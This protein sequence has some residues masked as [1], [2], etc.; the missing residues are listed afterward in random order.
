MVVYKKNL[1]S[2]YTFKAIQFWEKTASLILSREN[3][4]YELEEFEKGASDPN[5][6]FLKSNAF[7]SYFLRLSIK[8]KN[9]KDT[10][11]RLQEAKFRDSSYEV[12]KIFFSPHIV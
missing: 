3:I 11:G 1:L 9:F 5:R 7:I 2:L 4:I 6:Y 10:I 12:N 8:F